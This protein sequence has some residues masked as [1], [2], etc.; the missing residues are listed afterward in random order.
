[1]PHGCLLNRGQSP[2]DGS[3]FPCVLKP[4]DGAGSLA[5]QR[6]DHASELVSALW[7]SNPMRLEQFCPGV[8]CSAGVLGGPAGHVLLPPFRQRLSE[9]GR[10]SY[11]GGQL[12]CRAG[13]RLRAEHLAACAATILHDCVG[14]AG[15]DFVLGLAPDGSADVAVEINPRLTTSYIGLRHAVRENLRKPCWTW[16]RENKSA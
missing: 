16:R 11:L 10:F 5:V 8:P 2:P 4:L 14:Y 3:V 7:P 9:D 1:M 12:L 6:L 13:L 15:I